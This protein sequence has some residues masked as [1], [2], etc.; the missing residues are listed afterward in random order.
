MYRKISVVKIKQLLSGERD[1]SPV[2][3]PTSPIVFG[4]LDTEKGNKKKNPHTKR[5]FKITEFLVTQGFDR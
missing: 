3:N 4:W 1:T 5:G 2:I